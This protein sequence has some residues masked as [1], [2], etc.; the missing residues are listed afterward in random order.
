MVSHPLCGTRT[1]DKMYTTSFVYEDE[2]DFCRMIICRPDVVG[3]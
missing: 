3:H 1:S 2:E